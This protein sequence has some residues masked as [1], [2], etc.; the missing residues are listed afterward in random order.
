MCVVTKLLF[1]QFLSPRRSY[2]FPTSHGFSSLPTPPV[3]L[4]LSPSQTAF[5]KAQSWHLYSFKGM[6]ALSTLA[7]SLERAS[8]HPQSNPGSRA[9]TMA[10]LACS[11]DMLPRKVA[12]DILRGWSC[13]LNIPHGW[14]CE[15]ATAEGGTEEHSVCTG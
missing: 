3:P 6:K 9:E 1:M 13:D 7:K 4:S 10:A 5:D 14:S 11:L 12:L 15:W 2:L 8:K